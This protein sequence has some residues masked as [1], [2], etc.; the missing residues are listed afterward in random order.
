M[1]RSEEFAAALRGGKRVTGPGL[2]LTVLGRP[3]GP[4]RLGLAVK[5]PDAVTR[6]RIKRR[7]RAA[8]RQADVRGV[9]VVARAGAEVAGKD[10][11]ELVAQFRRACEGTG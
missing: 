4:G 7:L 2:A 5:A 3:A 11:Q 8:F 10:Y 9:D 1:R 6:N